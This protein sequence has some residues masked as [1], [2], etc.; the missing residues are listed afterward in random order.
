MPPA[1]IHQDPLAY[2]L[3]LEGVALLRAFAGEHGQAFTQARL[4]EVRS[5]LDRA[6]EIGPGVDVD[7]ISVR[8]GYDGW[9][10]TYDAEGNSCFPLRDE[11]LTPLLDRL[12]TGRVLDAAC[13]SGAVTR[14]LVDRGHDVVGVDGSPGMLGLA[15]RAVPEATLLEGD[16]AALPLPDADV[17][18]VTCTLALSHVTDLRP[19]FAEAARVMRPGGHLI[20]LDVRGYY[21]RSPL[22][23]LVKRTPDGRVG[24]MPGGSHETSDYLRA[25]LPHGFVVRACEEFFASPYAPRPD[26]EPAPLTPG[27]PDIWELAT[28]VPDAAAAADAGR[29][30]V[31][32]WDFELRPDV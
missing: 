2:L 25:A 31:V 32:A 12:L 5:L 7:P 26:A 21:P 3:G 13:G 10:A 9:S 22:F 18:H 28:W 29:S 27:P 16:L 20:T 14:Q 19:F 11:L 24:Y 17:D 1:P 4:A 30:Q 6:D 8:D 15:R 23:P